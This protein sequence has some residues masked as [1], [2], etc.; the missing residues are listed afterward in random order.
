MGINTDIFQ[1][2]KTRRALDRMKG[3]E[4]IIDRLFIIRSCLEYQDRLFRIRQMIERLGGEL[5][6]E[7]RPAR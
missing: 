3:P 4:N 7:F 5:H 2:K 6:H 1:V